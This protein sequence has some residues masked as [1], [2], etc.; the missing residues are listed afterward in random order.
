MDKVKVEQKLIAIPTYEPDK[1]CAHP[2]FLDKRVYQG[3]SGRVYPHPVTEHVS[4]EKHDKEYTAIFLENE[5]LI[6]MILPEIGGKIQRIYDKTNGYDAVYYNEVIKPALVGLAGPWVSGGIEFNWPLHHRPSAFEPI[7]FKIESGDDG[8]VTVWCGEIEKM[9]HTKGMAGIT[10]YPGKAYVEVKGQIYN[11]TEIPQTF[12][13]WANPAIAVNDNTRT[14]FPPDVHI[15]MDHAK[16]EISKFPV[17]TGRYCNA[18]YSE[19]V[20]IS[21]IKNI[22]VP[23]SYMANHSDYDFLGNYDSGAEAGLLHVADHHLSPGKKLWTW[24]SGDFG[25]AWY[26]NLT[27]G[28]GEYAELMAGIFSDNQPGFS[29]LMP[30]EEKTFKQYFMPY[31]KIGM[32]KNASKEIAANLEIEGRNAHIMIY[33]P[34]KIKITVLLSGSS[35]VSYMKKTAVVSPE[36]VFDEEIELD[37][38]EIETSLKLVIRNSN[39]DELLRYTP[40][41]E[42]HGKMPEPAKAVK[43]AKEISSMEELYLTAVHLEQYRHTSRRAEEYYLEGLRRDPLDIRLNNGYGKLVYKKGL[44][45][46]AERRFRAAIK[47]SVSLNPNPYDCEPYYNLGLSLKMQK[48][49]DEAYDAFYKSVWDGKMQEK[50]YY[51]LACVSAKM[52]KFE[53]A[54]EFVNQALTRGAHNMRARTLK[55][56]LLRREGRIEEG[57]RFAEE[58]IRIDPLDFGGRYEL[59]IMKGDFNI[60]NELTTIMR[61]ELQNYLEL[62]INYAEAN[63]Y[64]DAANVLALIAESD[65]PMLHYYMAYYSK[66]DVE[67]EVAEKCEKD[68]T[69]PNRLQ[70]I[71]VLS[72]AIEHNPSDWFARYCLGNLYYDR[73]VWFKAIKCWKEALK[74]SPRNGKIMRNLSISSYN[75]LKDSKEA[76]KFMERAALFEP[77][78]ARIYYELDLLRKLTNYPV[79][80]RLKDMA[81]KIE[82][83]ESR[84]DLFTEYITLLNSEGYYKHALRAIKRHNFHPWEGGEGKIS[85]QYK[86]AHMGCA[87]ECIADKDY[88]EAV[89]HL[90]KALVY[91]EN[92]GEG[93]LLGNRD[94]DVYY[95]L[96]CAY[97]QT[98]KIKSIEYFE[99]AAEGEFSLELPRYY[100]DIPADMYFFRSLALAKLGDGK[101]AKGGF[102]TLINYSEEHIDDIPEIDYFALS[103]TDFALFDEDLQRDNYVH[104]CY[105]AALGY[106]GKGM[107]EKSAEYI[108]KGLEKNC[109]HQG[110]LRLKNAD[111]RAPKEKTEDKTL[112]RAA[113]W[114]AKA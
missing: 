88:E 24:G 71:F 102:N 13:W 63:L 28:N 47:R 14:V 7:D 2:M 49:Y 83:I 37:D 36:K 29:F 86:T 101:K 46:E 68:Q 21:R 6:V 50:G 42:Y 3:C 9:Y 58:S 106:Y 72:Y 38:D 10:L 67:L 23:T 66:S 73:G 74:L 64:N 89:N 95:M 41:A 111:T 54:L 15:V 52:N 26:R 32:V 90:E 27:D 109:S 44:F 76:L 81:D 96:G 8:S 34:E 51:Q 4:E 85:M 80:K 75:K 87:K 62:S 94:N 57:I 25:K 12:L 97:E 104:C 100:K 56:A 20:D 70:E 103:I 69:F 92:L 18:D 79:K 107:K 84:D 82:I 48:R 108:E 105:L 77:E 55:C 39:G 61:G 78:D 114:D 45:D 99:K 19:G 43:P 33:A 59:F 1:I 5:Y 113:K 22:P 53:D 11:P 30:Y 98:D 65:K 112:L 93:K 17:S 16:R 110:L 35:A 31:K 60:L 91:P 40:E